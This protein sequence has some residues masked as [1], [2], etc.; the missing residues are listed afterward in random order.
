MVV[1]WKGRN[2]TAGTLFTNANRYFKL[3]VE[4]QV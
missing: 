3:L 2:S 4:A 1:A